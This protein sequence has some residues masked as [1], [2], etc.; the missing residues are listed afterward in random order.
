MAASS[1]PVDDIILM[2]NDVNKKPRQPHFNTYPTN[3]RQLN[4]G[5]GIRK[6]DKIALMLPCILVFQFKLIHVVKLVN[7][8]C[9][10]K[11]DGGQRYSRHTVLGS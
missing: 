5:S 9:L 2:Q 1:L 7:Y 8:I 11:E 10:I 3:I 4:L 6:T